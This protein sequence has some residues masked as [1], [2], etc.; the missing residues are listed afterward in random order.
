MTFSRGTLT[1]MKKKIESASTWYSKMSPLPPDGGGGR[2][3]NNL[4]T[5]S[6]GCPAL[7]RRA[8]FSSSLRDAA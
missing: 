6:L 7:K 3:K 8:I 5:K 2:L 4:A 1:G